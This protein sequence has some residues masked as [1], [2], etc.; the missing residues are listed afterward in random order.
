MIKQRDSFPTSSW[1]LNLFQGIGSK[2]GFTLM[3]LVVYMAIV[4]IIVIVAGQAFSNSTKFRVR[5]QNMLKATQQAENVGVLF[6]EDIQQT[7]TKTSKEVAV[8][9]SDNFYV[10]PS[11]YVAPEAATPDS[12]SFTITNQTENCGT[13]G[14]ATLSFASLRMVYTAAGLY[15][16]VEKVTWTYDK[17]AR[18]LYRSCQI[19]AAKDMNALKQDC[20]VDE[21]VEI[22]DSI[23][24]FRVVPAK[25]GVLSSG[26]AAASLLPEEFRLNPRLNGQDL[27]FAKT[28][29]ETGGS[30]VSITNFATNYDFEHSSVIENGTK[31]NEMFVAMAN[32]VDDTWDKCKK[33]NLSAEKEYEISF[34]VTYSEDAIR[35]FCPGRDHAAVGIRNSSDGSIIPLAAGSNVALLDDFLFYPPQSATG[36]PIR[37][38]RFTLSRAVSDACLAFTF[39]S[40]SPLAGNG[41]I[42]IANLSLQQV[43]SSNYTFDNSFAA[44]MTAWDKKNV[45]AVRLDLTVRRNNETGEVSV[46]VPIPSNGT[47]D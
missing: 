11:V 18:K 28:T 9:T 4:G 31:R 40:Y 44:S 3:E 42:Q 34:N 36:S 8:E 39:S 6:K 1:T 22:A 32:A 20:R 17:D 27:L 19:L 13:K 38:M 47:R 30:A 23:A 45:K 7:G 35:M 26:A 33:F 5:T 15:K 2:N 46:V 12:S 16:G 37:S 14:C 29:P 25:P 10:S 24:F 43:A 41:T 21:T